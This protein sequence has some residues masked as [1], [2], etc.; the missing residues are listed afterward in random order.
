MQCVEAFT[1]KGA[2]DKIEKALDDKIPFDFLI[3]DHR[4]SEV[5]LNLN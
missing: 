5:Q 4:D 3:V 1:E 2:I